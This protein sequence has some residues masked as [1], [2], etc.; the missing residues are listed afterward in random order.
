MKTES[1][2]KIVKTQVVQEEEMDVFIYIAEDGKEF[3]D[4][5]ECEKYE[6]KLALDKAKKAIEKLE[7]STVR[8]TMPLSD[9]GYPSEC[10]YF[11]WYKVN[12]DTDVELLNKVYRDEIEEPSFY[13]EIICVE[14]TEGPSDTI[15]D[16]YTY[17]LTNIKNDTINFWKKFGFDVT[18]EEIEENKE[19]VVDNRSFEELI[20]ALNQEY[21][22]ITT[23]ESL[24][25]FAKA[26]I[27]EDNLLLANHVLEA[28]HADTAD[29]YAYD[30]NM[31]TMETP[32]AL[33]SVEDL[34][35]F[36]NDFQPRCHF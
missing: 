26:K 23:Y 15:F 9:D 3:E 30:Y 25:E 2:R 21:D 27:D 20:D 10:N 14:T 28:I 8:S 35:E 12:S 7:L 36:L 5:E 19:P 13:P 11:H 33:K 18:F 29:W 6:K 34:E 16:V 1:R 31:G 17:Y 22:N 24:K 32:R 4:K